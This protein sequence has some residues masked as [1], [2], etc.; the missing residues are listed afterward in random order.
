MRCATFAGVLLLLLCPMLVYAQ[1]GRRGSGASGSTVTAPPLKGVVITFHGALKELSKK[2]ILLQ[3]DDNQLVTLRRTSK[4]KFM[5]Q[6]QK[7]KADDF[8]LEDKV[9]IDATE[10]NDLKLL[11]MAVHMDPGPPRK[12]PALVTR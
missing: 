5:K 6:D 4:T 7:L 10:D 1:R 11:A 12:E 8:D 9:S 3:T 2:T